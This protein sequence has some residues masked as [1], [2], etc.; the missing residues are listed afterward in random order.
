MGSTDALA[1]KSADKEEWLEREQYITNNS[2]R[3]NSTDRWAA[4]IKSADM[5][6]WPSNP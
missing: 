6:G 5:V 1:P 2:L 4:S 3:A